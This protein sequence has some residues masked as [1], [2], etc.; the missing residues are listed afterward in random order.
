V[1]QLTYFRLFHNLPEADYQLLQS[2]FTTRVAKKGE[3]LTKPGQVQRDLYFCTTGV[4]MSY[5]ETDNKLHV[6]AFT[7]P[8]NPCAIP[9]SFHAQRPSNYFLKCLTDSEFQSISF[10]QLQKLFDQSRELERLFRKMTE[11]LL[12][13]VLNRHVELHALSMEE[14]YLQFCRRS[15]HLLQLVPH[16]YLASYL[17]IDSTN[18][19][20]LF[21]SIKI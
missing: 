13:G 21:N 14:R 16:K 10:D 9:E 3:L 20:K 4:Q 6:I 12:A 17:G 15:P 8:P 18:F 19:S 1:D 11:A 2:C 7:Y 5:L